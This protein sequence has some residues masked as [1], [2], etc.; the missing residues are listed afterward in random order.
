MNYIRQLHNEP[1]SPF[2]K[3]VSKFI[4]GRSGVENVGRNKGGP[5]HKKEQEDAGIKG[6]TEGI[7]AYGDFEEAAS[8]MKEGLSEV[9]SRLNRRLGKITNGRVVR[10]FRGRCWLGIGRSSS[11]CI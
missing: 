11:F 8:K 7:A 4:E 10:L 6:D 3:V 9:L 1:S 5:V 2:N